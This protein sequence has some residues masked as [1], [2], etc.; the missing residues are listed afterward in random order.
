MARPRSV[1]LSPEEMIALGKEMVKFVNDHTDIQEDKKKYEEILHLSEWYTIEKKFT[2]NEWKSF[3]QKEEFIP[4]YE[5][6]LK[7]IAKKYINGTINPSIAQRFLRI[8][9]ADLK[10]QENEDLDASS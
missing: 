4:Y 6:A 1:S 5:Q 8:Y 9:F 10:L 7:I 2:Y 3:I